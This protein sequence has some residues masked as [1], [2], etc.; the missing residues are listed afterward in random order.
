MFFMNYYSNYEEYYIT[1]INLEFVKFNL[2]I[3]LI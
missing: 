1:F 2:L 3:Y